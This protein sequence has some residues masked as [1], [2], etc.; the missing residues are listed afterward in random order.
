MDDIKID[1][2]IYDFD[3][4]N[5]KQIALGIADCISKL[6]QHQIVTCLGEE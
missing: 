2:M 4:I 6:I 3:S 5:N 1:G